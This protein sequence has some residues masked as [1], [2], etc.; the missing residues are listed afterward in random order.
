MNDESSHAG[1]CLA[2][3]GLFECE[4]LVRLMLKNWGHPLADDE[5]FSER[6][7]EAASDLLREADKSHDQSTLIDGMKNGDLN[8][9][10]A[11]WYCENVALAHPNENSDGRQRWLE[12]VRRALPSCFCDPNDLC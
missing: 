9:V 6:L 11:V 8:L 12:A 5:D 4:I 1:Q 3:S 2:F 7:L 10:A